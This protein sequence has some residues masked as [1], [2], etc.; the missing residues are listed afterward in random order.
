MSG[1]FICNKDFGCL[2][3]KGRFPYRG[4]TY[5]YS[6]IHVL[7]RVCGPRLNTGPYAVYPEYKAQPIY[8]VTYLPPLTYTLHVRTMQAPV[9]APAPAPAPAHAP[10][11]STQPSGNAATARRRAL[12]P[13]RCLCA[14]GRFGQ[15]SRSSASGSR[16]GDRCAADVLHICMD[17]F[18]D[19]E[20]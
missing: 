5:V 13:S 15:R 20:P 14:S 9:P 4:N 6:R 19:S 17:V 11:A 1:I 10:R 12:L 3:K 16:W 8:Y 2:A 7:I 18:T